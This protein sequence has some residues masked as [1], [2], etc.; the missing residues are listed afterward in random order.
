MPS[1]T[2]FNH[3]AVDN[4][5]RRGAMEAEVVEAV[6]SGERASARAGR[7]ECVK[8]FTYNNYWNGKLYSTKQVVPIIKEETDVTVVIPVYAYYF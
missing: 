8:N 6:M 5:K 2:V 1:E 7:I 3:H 4:L